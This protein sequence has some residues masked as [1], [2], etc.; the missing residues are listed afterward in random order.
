M[1]DEPALLLPHGRPP[2]APRDDRG[3]W[4]PEPKSNV[5]TSRGNS[6]TYIVRRLARGGHHVLIGMIL[7][8]EISA[9]AAARRAGFGGPPRSHRPEPEQ[10]RYD[11]K[12]MIA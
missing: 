2:D 5:V 11:V 8:R 3:R 7:N 9:R 10:R 4:L 12:A 6:R 1:D